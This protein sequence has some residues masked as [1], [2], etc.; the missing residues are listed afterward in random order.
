MLVLLSIV[1]II[2][3]S[4]AASTS[5][6][7]K[8]NGGEGTITL[9]YEYSEGN[10]T[11]KPIS[12]VRVSIYKVADIDDDLQV[13][14][15]GKFNGYDS[16][17]SELYG[18]IKTIS[19]SEDMEKLYKAINDAVMAKDS[20]IQS[21][22]YKTTGSSGIA[23]FTNLEDGI[24]FFVA[25]DVVNGKIVK[26]YAAPVIGVLPVSKVEVVDENDEDGNP[27]KVVKFTGELTN[28]VELYFKVKVPDTTQ[29]TTKPSPTPKPNKL[30][31]T[32]AITWQIDV[33]KWSC[34]GVCIVALLLLVCYI[35][36]GKKKGF[37]YAAISATVIA[38][39]LLIMS[40]LVKSANDYNDIQAGNS[41][42][43]VV[44][45]LQESRNDTLSASKPEEVKE[46]ETSKEM[47]TKEVDGV[48]YVGTIQLPALE[49]ELPVV[50]EWNEA[51]A[52]IG[53]CLYD[54]NIYDKNMV[55]AG[56]NYASHFGY[57]GN[58]KEGDSVV[59]IDVDGNSTN[60][61]VEKQEVLDG[62][63]VD[64]MCS[65]SNGLTLFTCTY[66]GTERLTIRCK[67]M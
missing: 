10:A 49:L 56:H 34:L 42:K 9:H 19:K 40:L 30:P 29:S 15:T 16:S 39:C 64:G 13:S 23:K 11:P 61:E 14:T 54:G 5:R 47:K 7:Y 25:K 63:D 51:N 2:V 65:Y 58:L 52:E 59:F 8:G 12:G 33:L 62:Y 36:L 18:A 41:A 57:I 66:S 53:P 1:S 32:G 50:S 38:I 4:S 45:A 26:Y 37:I 3:P 55:L 22:G 20:T 60:Y 48:L 67:E 17:L 24:Y 31:Q 21:D 44:S 28:E 27:V 35:E 43:S 46:R 6:E